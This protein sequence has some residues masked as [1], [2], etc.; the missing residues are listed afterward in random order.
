[1][2]CSHR[3]LTRDRAPCGRER[4]TAIVEGAFV[5]LSFFVIICILFEGTA[6]IRD[7]LGVAN[8]ARTAARTATVNGDEVYADYY[9]L[10]TVK[11]EAT[12]IGVD[13][14]KLVVVYEASGFGNPPSATCKAGTAVSTGTGQCNVYTRSDLF[15]PQTDFACK[16]G[17][18]DV[19]W[20]PNTRKVAESG[21]AGPPDYLGIY[22]KYTHDLIT[23]LFKGQ[24]TITDFVVIRMEPR[25]LA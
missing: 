18:P 9:I 14:L 12:A 13:D 20:C 8:L 6:L 3:A 19:P 11:K 21:S 7:S 22:I 17:G 23:G 15:R 25:K 10:R 24:S 2:V 1:V 4:G 5:S 16:T